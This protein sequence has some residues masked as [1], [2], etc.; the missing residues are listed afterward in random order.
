MPGIISA[1]IKTLTRGS[2]KK[3]T[4]K[5]T[6]NNKQQFDIIDILYMRLGYTV[7][8]EWGNSIYTTNGEDKEILRNTLIEEKFFQSYGSD[9]YLTFLNDIEAKRDKHAGNYDALL[10]KVSNF[11]WSFNSDGSYDIELT[12]IS[13][14]DVIESLKSNLSVDK[15][16]NKFLIAIKSAQKISDTP[17]PE[18]APQISNPEFSSIQ[19]EEARKEVFNEALK[20]YND[21]QLAKEKEK[22]DNPQDEEVIDDE[23]S[24]A[25]TITALL[26]IWKYISQDLSALT[27]ADPSNSQAIQLVTTDNAGQG[28][29]KTIGS[30]LSPS[31]DESDFTAGTVDVVFTITYLTMAD[32]YYRER[33]RKENEFNR[34]V[35]RIEESGMKDYGSI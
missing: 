33:I 19:S 31:V 34:R 4:V 6:A 17:P 32:Y 11:S 9:S 25:D 29:F 24:S 21:A 2:L 20:T 13:L 1:D 3:A 23:N 5:L 10:G 26:T 15:A 14:G 27:T 16:T 7:L 35:L 12:I 8:L 28:D 18:T 30:L 22:K